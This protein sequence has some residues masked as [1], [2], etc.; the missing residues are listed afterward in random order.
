MNKIKLMEILARIP[1]FKNLSPAERDVVQNMVRNIKRYPQGKV[2]IKEGAHEPFFY[3]ILAGK[4]D[5]STRGHKIGELISGQFIGEVGFICSEPR[6]ATVSAGTDIALMLINSE[7]FRRLPAR[8]RESI[9]DRIISGLVERV[10][11][12]NNNTIRYEDEIVELKEKVDEYENDPRFKTRGSVL[13]EEEEAATTQGAE[14]KKRGRNRNWRK[15]VQ[16]MPEQ[17]T[18]NALHSYNKEL[19]KNTPEENNEVDNKQNSQD[20]KQDS[21]QNSK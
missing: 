20:A 9:K 7:D 21:K 8:I 17:E 18:K 14:V 1:L 6:S 2:F 13:N 3:I 4:A 5:V 19:T 16:R 10:S 15:T 12:M 11:G